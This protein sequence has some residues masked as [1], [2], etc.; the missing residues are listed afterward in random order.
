MERDVERRPPLHE[1]IDDED[2]DLDEFDD[3]EQTQ[4]DR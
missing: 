2:L 4:L 1:E 3:V